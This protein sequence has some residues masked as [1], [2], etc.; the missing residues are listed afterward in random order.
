MRGEDAQPSKICDF[1][2][3]FCI[4]SG[5]A[6]P[7]MSP[8][9]S[10]FTHQPHLLRK[11]PATMGLRRLSGLLLVLTMANLAFVGSDVVCAKHAGGH[12]AAPT[13]AST[14]MNHHDGDTQ[15]NEPCNIP[16]RSDCCQMVTSCAPSMSLA[17][18][19]SDLDEVF[20]HH[21]QPRSIDELPLTRLIPPDPPPPKV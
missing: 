5:S 15:P 6:G 17:A 10:A 11:F 14:D 9:G 18:A 7:R 2:S 3:D 21:E 12:H 19:V 13:S 20:T 1:L 4:P 8:D 16:A